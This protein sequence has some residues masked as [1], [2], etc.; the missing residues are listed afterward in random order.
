MEPA[1]VRR[2]VCGL[3]PEIFRPGRI[4]VPPAF[5]AG[6]LSARGFLCGLL[7]GANF[8]E[9]A[10]VSAWASRW[11]APAPKAPEPLKKETAES[12]LRELME[13]EEP[14]RRN[15]IFILA[16][17]LERRRILVEK[18]VQWQPDGRKIRVYEHKQTG[19]SFVVP[20]PQLRLREIE[21]VQR[22]VMDLLGIH[23]PND[24]PQTAQN[25]NPPQNEVKSPEN[26][27]KL[28]KKA[29][30]SEKT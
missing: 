1:G 17:M 20:D 3:R 29:P 11:C 18:E 26:A 6:R 21:H 4:N 2:P 13:T 19:E 5:H 9:G 27:E 15:A 30:K 14:S 7:A 10:E 28:T 24:T 25:E 23:A 12:L 22:Q 8:V 16:V